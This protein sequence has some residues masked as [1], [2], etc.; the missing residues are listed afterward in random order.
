MLKMDD[1]IRN[2]FKGVGRS[3]QY[4]ASSSRPVI[5]PKRSQPSRTPSTHAV[6]APPN[7]PAKIHHRKSKK[8]PIIIV[9]F[10]II[11]SL[12]AG[13]FIYF[14]KNKS[15]Q[16]PISASTSTQSETTAPVKKIRLIATGDNLAFDSINNAAKKSDGSYDYLPIMSAMKPFF[17]ASEIRLCNQTTPSGGEIGGISGY[18]SFNAPEAWTVGLLDLGCNLINLASDHINDKG[19]PTID[20][21]ISNFENRNNLLAIAGA[22]RSME[23]QSKIRYFT[24]EGLK[25]AFL[26]YATSTLNKQVTSYGLNAY[27]DEQA[28]KDIAEARKNADFVIVGINWGKENSVDINEE[29]DRIAQNLANQNVDLVIG[30]GLRVVQ[31]VKILEGTS[32]NKTFVWFSLGNFVNSQLPINNLIGGVAVMDIDVTTKTIDPPKFMPT[33]MHYEWTAAQKSAGNINAR[34]NFKILPLDLGAEALAKSLNNTTVEAQTD[35]V[36]SIL[37]KF[38]PVTIITSTQYFE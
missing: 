21:T 11:G 22:N 12:G 31:P 1:D 24:G 30:G 15:S 8:L 19:Q 23:E 38:T 10:I 32:G 34:Q 3:P 17:D 13:I 9:I 25:F 14:F 33:Y 4:R 6:P 37:N 7:V 2:R 5:L 26:A 28:N 35:S 18:P 29:Q 16:K 36:K 20:K 27:S